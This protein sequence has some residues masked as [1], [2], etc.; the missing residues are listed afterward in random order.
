MRGGSTTDDSIEI[1]GKA[2][3]LHQSLT[4]SIRAA[5]EMRVAWLRAIESLRQRFR[6]FRR[7]MYGEIS[8]IH[9]TVG[10]V[11]RPPRATSRR[12]FVTRVGAY[13]QVSRCRIGENAPIDRPRVATIPAHQHSL[14]PL[15]RKHRRESGTSPDYPRHSAVRGAHVVTMLE[16]I[17]NVGDFRQVNIGD[18]QVA[19][20]RALT[21]G[22]GSD[23]YNRGGHRR[24]RYLER[25]RTSAEAKEAPQK[26]RQDPHHDEPRLSPGM[27]DR[28]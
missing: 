13:R 22:D 3:G 15:L 20:T 11:E 9:L 27:S 21:G 2:L 25:H 18:T 14:V 8:E 19:E 12:A 23:R 6:G 10:I 4:A 7:A 17:G 28:G 24:R 16:R 1:V 5:G 26:L